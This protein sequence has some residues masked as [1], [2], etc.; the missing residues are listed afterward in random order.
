MTTTCN[1][2]FETSATL[3]KIILTTKLALDIFKLN[4][5]IAKE[6]EGQSDLCPNFFPI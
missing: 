5:S 4:P 2:H 3:L 1:Y 6:G